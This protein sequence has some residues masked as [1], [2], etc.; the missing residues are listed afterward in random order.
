MWK[1]KYAAI[2]LLALLLAAYTLLGMHTKNTNTKE[3]A[4]VVK[5]IDGDTVKL[6]NGEKVRLI[7]VNAPE[8]G[9]AYYK[10]ARER[11]SSL[12]EGKGVALERDAENRDQ[13][14]RLLRYIFLN[15]ENMNIKMVREGLAS[16]YIIQPNTSY[17]K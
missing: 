2:L 9:H 7:G 16:A 1:R 8:R 10:K 15:G 11:L 5:V 4:F 13:Y 17:S 12:I 6:A 3:L 14:G